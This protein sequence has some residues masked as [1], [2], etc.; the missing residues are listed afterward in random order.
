MIDNLEL[1]KPL[2]EFNKENDFYFIQ[3]LQ[4]KK[5]N[6]EVNGLNNSRTVKSY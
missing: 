5:D 2:L 6:P 3:I 4:R 1:I